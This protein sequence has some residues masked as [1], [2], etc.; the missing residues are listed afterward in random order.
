MRIRIVTLVVIFLSLVRFEVPSNA[1]QNYTFRR[2]QVVCVIAVRGGY[3]MERKTPVPGTTTQVSRRPGTP[4]PRDPELF[5]SWG[6]PYPGGVPDSELKRVIEQEFRKRNYYELA[7]FADEADLVF[8]VEAF[9]SALISAD[10]RP[11]SAGSFIYASDEKPNFLSSAVAIA[12][13]TSSYRRYLADSNSLLKTAVWRGIVNSDHDNPAKLEELVRRFHANAK[14]PGDWTLDTLPQYPR[15]QVPRDTASPGSSLTPPAPSQPAA[16][17]QTIPGGA[18]IK[19]DVTMVSVPVVVTDS[20]GKR[21]PGLEGPDFRLFE[22]DAEQRLDRLLSES[23]PF[24]VAL[25]VDASA[26]MRA[27]FSQIRKTVGVFLESLRREDRVMAVSFGSIVLLN[28][29][30]TTDRDQLRQAILRM[31]LSGLSRLYDGLALTLAERLNWTAGRRAVVLLTD[32]L[33]VGS[34][35]AGAADALARFAVSDVPVYVVQYDTKLT[36]INKLPSGWK[37][38]LIPEGYLDK[39]AAYA[40]ASRFLQDLSTTSGGR[41]EQAG[42]IGSLQEAF[43]RIA[44]ELRRQYTLCY[45]PS[46]QA[47]DGSLRRIRVEVNRPGVKVRARAEYRAAKSP[48]GK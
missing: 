11:N 37:I 45:Y 31:S 1:T 2:G 32:G 35:L 34:G 47:R 44:E 25:I 5:P 38:R 10:T 41:L 22:D 15:A 23:E 36:N 6:E 39:D 27:D 48:A 42:N 33:D 43:A 13:P 18:T 28:S 29:E 46:N 24:N 26:S 3:I 21:V 19:V 8:L 40:S 12:V 16:S 14:M 9:Q 4:Q 17:S 20:E 7:A 30:W